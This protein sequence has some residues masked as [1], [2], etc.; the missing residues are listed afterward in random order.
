MRGSGGGGGGEVELL[1]RSGA[2]GSVVFWL[3]VC[4]CNSCPEGCRQYK[5]FTE[6]R[7]PVGPGLQ[8]RTC[9]NEAEQLEEKP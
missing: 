7:G 5:F 3:C 8:L 2:G 4:V 9:S 6:S 1:V